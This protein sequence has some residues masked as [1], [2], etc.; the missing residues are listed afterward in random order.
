MS[1]FSDATFYLSPSGY[2]EGF[3]FP[4]KPISSNG[5]VT[6]TRAGSAWRTNLEGQIEESPYNIYTYSEDYS[7]V[8][9]FASGLNAFGSGSVSNTTAT[10]D[11]LGGN[12]ADYIQENTTNGTHILTNI[13]AGAIANNIFTVSVYAKPSERTIISFLNNGGG[14]GVANFNLSTGV[15]TL[16][17]GGISASMISVGNGWYRCVMTYVPNATGNL[18][19]HIRLCDASGN[20]SYSGTGTSGAYIWGSQIVQGSLPKNYLY[21]SN[22]QNFPRIDY[23]LGTGNLLLE[24]QRTNS[25]RNSTMV[26]AVVGVPGTIPTNW[27]P[28]AVAGLT[29]EIIALGTEN[30]LNYIDYKFSGTATGSIVRFLF[31]ST[32]QIVASN[33]QVWTSS[34]YGKIISGTFD[35]S[36]FGFI[37]RNN[38]GGNLGLLSQSGTF[39]SVFNRISTTQTVNQATTAFVQPFL[40]FYVTSSVSYNFTIRIA[41]PQMELGTYATTPIPTT[42]ASATRLVDAFNRSNL[43]TNNLISASGGTWLL[44]LR[45]STTYIRDI[46][47]Q[48]ISLG[49]FFNGVGTDGFALTFGQSTPTGFQFR[50]YVGGVETTIYGSS[51]GTVKL[52]IKWN[53]STADLF[54][55]GVKQVSATVFTATTMSYLFATGA[56]TPI[57]ILQTALWNTPLT[58]T[59][60]IELTS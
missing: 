30:G 2:K 57:N 38:V 53:G 45:N 10:Q 9:W 18:N 27:N 26:G 28:V 43:Y 13:I 40:D 50:K 56:S 34:L 22:R 58:D 4:Q 24:P 12:T 54:V 29:S 49:Y 51:T 14:G 32:S 48:S 23:S 59:Q 11:P 3:I 46:F 5:D 16:V 19:V 52:L 60:S 1:K 55:N 6:F 39:T 8:N 42:T 47:S 36:A 7:N 35:S 41:Q 44:D 20:S 15:A 31:E 17:S 25:I 21:T 37:Q 33:G